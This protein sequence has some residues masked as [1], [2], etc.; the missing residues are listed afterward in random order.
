MEK[1]IDVR[2]NS[3]LKT[4]LR[5]R[6]SILVLA[7]IMLFIIMAFL[8][9]TTFYKSNNLFNITKQI[10]ITAI[11]AIGQSFVLMTGGINLCV[12]YSC[13]LNGIIMAWFLVNMGVSEGVGMLLCVLAGLIVG[14]LNGIMITRINLPPFIVT[15]GMSNILQGCAY[16]IT[17]G[18]PISLEPYPTIIS[19]GSDYVGPI[20][21][22]TIIMLVLVIFFAIILARSTFGMRVLSIG[23]NETAAHLSG[24]NVRKYKVLVYTISG[25]L[26]GIAGVIMAGRLGTGNPSAGTTTDMDTIAAAIIGGT[27]L[28][29]GEGTIAGTFLGALCIGVI[30]NAMV[31]MGINTYWQ[32][33]MIG[34][35]IL[36][37]TSIDYLTRSARSK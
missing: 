35:V 18:Y 12:G 27:S 1:K 25:L 22:M 7:I 24:I 11:V 5:R 13:S 28:S 3:Y 37:I 17:R 8:R 34:V 36:V 16:L 33:V 19:I 14:L 23:G 6:E 10:S 15:M 29:G 26:C 20:P 21:I 30:K 9:P 2:K 4:I 31:L 32:Y